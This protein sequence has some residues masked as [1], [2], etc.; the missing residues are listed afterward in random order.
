MFSARSAG[1]SGAGKKSGN[2]HCGTARAGRKRRT[3]KAACRGPSPTV[4]R[5]VDQAH[6]GQHP[7]PRY[8][9]IANRGVGGD[10][11]RQQ[12]ETKRL[13]AI[14]SQVIVEIAEDGTE[15]LDLNSVGAGAV[16]QSSQTV[17]GGGVGFGGDIEAA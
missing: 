2:R 8:G 6:K 11:L 4:A 7:L 10:E 9:S 12:R 3:E 16:R 14:A 15:R 17:A 5:A 1:S 13:A